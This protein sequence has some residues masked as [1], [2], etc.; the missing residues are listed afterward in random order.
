MK[1]VCLLLVCWRKVLWVCFIE[2]ML[3]IVVILLIVI[4]DIGFE[5]FLVVI[6]VVVFLIVVVWICSV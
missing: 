3:G 4:E 1:E 6:I 2:V 5:G